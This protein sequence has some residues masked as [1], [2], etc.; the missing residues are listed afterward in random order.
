MEFRILGPLELAVDGGQIGLPGRKM[1]RLLAI[2]LCRAGSVVSAD[3]LIEALRD[4]R[5]G[6][7]SRKALQIQVHRLRKALGRND[8]ISY[9]PP[10]YIAILAPSALDAHRFEA[11]A[12][13]GRNMLAAGDCERARDVLRQALA[14]WRGQPLAGLHDVEPLRDEATRLT[15]LHLSATRDRIDA[16]L[17]LGLHTELVAE[18]RT[19][20]D[21]H[22][23]RE[24]LRTQLMLAL[25]RCG[26][27]AEALEVCREGRRLLLDEL[28]VDPGPELRQLE[29]AMLAG[30]PALD[31]WNPTA[32]QE[33]VAAQLPHDIADFTGREEI[34]DRVTGSLAPG[35]TAV[36]IVMLAGRGGIGKTALAVHVAHL[37]RP[38]FPDGQ[39][40]VNLA[41]TAEEPLDP[42]RVLGRF[43]RAL[44]VDSS[45]IPT[46]ID[47]RAELYRQRLAAR[48]VLVVLDDA[49]GEAQVRPLLPGSASCAVIATSRTPLTGLA[50]QHVILDEFDADEA[51]Q[52]LGRIAGQQRV[53][54]QS[55]SAAEISRLCGHL[56]LAIRIAGARL[57]NRP[58]L[59]LSEL[60]ERLTEAGSRLDVLV[61]GDMGV[62]A[63]FALSYRALPDGVQR[64]FRLLGTLDVPDFAAWVPAAMLD[65]TVGQAVSLTDTLVDAQLLDVTRVDSTGQ[66]RYRFHDLVQDYAQERAAAEESA[67]ARVDAF[68]RACGAWLAL[69]ESAGRGL[70]CTRLA[71]VSGTTPRWAGALEHDALASNALAWFDEE[72]QSLLSIAAQAARLGLEGPAWELAD[73]L[74]AFCELRDLYDEGLHVHRLAL[75]ACELAGDARGTAVM[76]RNL[77]GLWTAKPGSSRDQRREYAQRALAMLRRLGERAAEADALCLCGDSYR[78]DGD[79]RL[80][81]STLYEAVDTASAA[82]HR[83][84]VL[85]A[86]QQIAGIHR[87][88]GRYEECAAYAEKCIGLAGELGSSRD[89]GVSLMLLG[90][91]RREQGEVIHA[92]ACFQEGIT[93]C[94]A[95]GDHAQKAYLLAH[96]GQL[97]AGQ[98][99]PAARQT[100]ERAASL[101]RRRNLTFGLALSLHGLGEVDFAEGAHT[102]A[103]DRFGEAVRLWRDSGYRFA[104]ARTLKRLGSALAAKGSGKEAVAAWLEAHV[105]YEELNNPAEVRE[106]AQLLE[107]SGA[108]I[109]AS[110]R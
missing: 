55:A 47:E 72:H 37:L 46:G 105:L 24:H 109:S 60:V 20:V 12:A 10:G 103:V 83:P 77:A 69:A 84:G 67:A 21:E 82:G 94:E 2:L 59:P 86:W 26:R 42:A 63:C 97:Y 1:Q 101:S 7:M 52:L 106:L 79:H 41:G 68:T 40:Y 56:P 75:E 92:E 61:L 45:A 11:L 23:L 87:A 32:R 8:V 108:P 57:A 64:A 31:P 18:L 65:V 28:G 43:L 9:R 35:G 110:S 91:I 89:L 29:L 100:L 15:E 104:L 22:P 58:R 50:G 95:S 6:R 96:L 39:L 27:Q 36:S 93:I 44:G 107:A 54:A 88:Q 70:P 80:A 49:A 13:D 19:L 78:V 3:Q 25:Y 33:A 85:H 71:P 53:A 17:Q 62:R 73:S 38:S 14:L 99:H 51:V 30:D 81:L 4:E 66:V 76:L 5:Q 34:I 16:E 98:R 48:R 102:A 90:I 74:Q